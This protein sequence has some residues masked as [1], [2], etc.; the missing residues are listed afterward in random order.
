MFSWRM[1]EVVW[2]FISMPY[3][4]RIRYKTPTHLHHCGSVNNTTRPAGSGE[5]ARTFALIRVRLSWLV[6]YFKHP[7]SIA[8]TSYTIRSSGVLLQTGRVF[9]LCTK[10]TIT[11]KLLLIS[12]MR[13]HSL[14]L[15]S[16]YGALT[17]STLVMVPSLHTGDGSLTPHW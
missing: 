14:N 5:D 11:I 4:I 17:H 3:I 6:Y 9:F 2:T 7:R 1:S 10:Y 16:Y 8:K 12:L 15:S 13:Q